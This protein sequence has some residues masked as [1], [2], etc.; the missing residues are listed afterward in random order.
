M[1]VSTLGSSVRVRASRVGVS[2]A[3]AMV[4]A[5]AGAHAQNADTPAK[6]RDTSDFGRRSSVVLGIDNVFGYLN[7]GI[8]KRGGDLE[9][10]GFFPGVYGPR[11]GFD[12]VGTNGLTIG[13]G[14][15]L[16][17]AHLKGSDGDATIVHLAPRIGY[18]APLGKSVGAWIRGGPNAMSQFAKDES[19]IYLSLRLEAFFVVT[20]VPHFGLMLG[21]SLD[22]GL[23]TSRSK[24]S[25]E[26]TWHSQGFLLGMFGEL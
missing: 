21:P 15:Q 25:S 4:L 7:E 19:Q 3:L 9:D 16:W 22:F 1:A 23:V 26:G 13:T 24:G 6:P 20:P 8:S 14:L 18:A 12:S 2:L 17:R 5:A 10:K 11:F